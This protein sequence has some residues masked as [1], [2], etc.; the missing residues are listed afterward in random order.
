MP[1]SIGEPFT[2]WLESDD[3]YAIGSS[4]KNIVGGEKTQKTTFYC[5][6]CSANVSPALRFCSL[7]SFE[8]REVFLAYRPPS[9]HKWDPVF[10][11]L[12]LL[13]FF[14]NG[15]KRLLRH[16]MGVLASK[17]VFSSRPVPD[18]PYSP[19]SF[20]S[21]LIATLTKTIYWTVWSRRCFS[22]AD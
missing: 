20:L 5:L 7:I 12:L 17:H 22:V 9:A 2:F 10:F 21:S 19:F 6:A 15:G 3:L 1:P 14:L 13:L 8:K 4:Q 16:K 11:S 18:F